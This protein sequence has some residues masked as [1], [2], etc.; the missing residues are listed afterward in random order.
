MCIKVVPG[1]TEQSAGIYAGS[2][3]ATF[4]IGRAF[5]SY[6]WGWVADKYGRKQVFYYCYLLCTIFSLG[7][8]LSTSLTMIAINRFFLGLFNGTAETV[9]TMCFEI[10]DGDEE[11]QKLV[12]GFVLSMRSFSI[13][14][15]LLISGIISDPV[16][17]FSDWYIS[18]HYTEFL[19]KYPYI[20]PNVVGALI[21]LVGFLTALLGLKETNPQFESAQT[22]ESDNIV[23]GRP[24]VTSKQIWSKPGARDHLITYWG[25]VY[26]SQFLVESNRLYFMATDGG[27]SLQEKEIGI[28]SSTAGLLNIF[29]QYL[30][31]ARILYKFGLNGVQ[32][33][34]SALGT[35][36]SILIPIATVL[37]R[38][39]PTNTLTIQAFTYCV[40]ITAT[41]RTF[42]NMYSFSTTVGANRS[43]TKEE[44]SALNALSVFGGSV[45]Q[46][47]APFLAGY[48]TTF[49]L[50]NETFDPT[51][52]I[53]V[54]FGI[55]STVG[56]LL[57]AF[58]FCQ[59][60]KYYN[61]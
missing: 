25:L 31:Y 28:V 42:Q 33:I 40:I 39:T 50:S 21:C 22:E 18:T 9:K 57:S 52:G 17:Q 26:C 36:L 23:S 12:T 60:S 11:L 3:S 5:S 44:R 37:N 61:D 45:S 35:P 41:A 53:Y 59:L 46:A 29:S 6:T 8:G 20:L 54:T 27:L 38:G 32:K 34:A 51:V 48:I 58:T 19:T 15:T 24:K 14:L 10:A 1:L 7:F 16:K 2:L 47:L 55:A 43:V 30:V 56:L 13:F 49:A 4:M